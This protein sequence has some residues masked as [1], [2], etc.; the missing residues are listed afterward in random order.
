MIKSCTYLTQI[1]KYHGKI[2]NTGMQLGTIRNFYLKTILNVENGTFMMVQKNSQKHPRA[3]CVITS[4][5]ILRFKSYFDK[6]KVK[7]QNRTIS[8]FGH[9]N[10]H[11]FLKYLQQN[12]YIKTTFR[13]DIGKA[14]YL[15][16]S[17]TKMKG[18]YIKS[19]SKIMSMQFSNLTFAHDMKLS[20]SNTKPYMQKQPKKS[21]CNTKRTPEV[22][23]CSMDFK[24]NWITWITYQSYQ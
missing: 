7:Y 12:L 18:T 15:F 17:F 3:T 5:I 16:T 6:F 10:D 24:G 9:W 8:K 14:L 22:V 20:K 23:I 19:T 2:H 13:C 4:L 21:I 1:F 11:N